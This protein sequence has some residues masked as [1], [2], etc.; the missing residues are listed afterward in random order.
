M[1]PATNAANAAL[2][3]AVGLALGGGMVHGINGVQIAALETAHANAQRAAAAAAVERLTAAQARG[4]AITAD[5]LAARAE[6]DTLQEQLHEALARQTTGR[7]CLGGGALRLLDRATQ[8]ARGLPAPT[9]RP[10]A[11]DAESVATDTQVAGW[12]ANAYHHYAEC[13][14]RLD[15]LI[16]YHEAP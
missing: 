7:P 9:G 10:A 12:A 11:A 13:A 2:V 16:D 15:A 6:A 4:D 5:L 1:N 14:R 3:F 8:P